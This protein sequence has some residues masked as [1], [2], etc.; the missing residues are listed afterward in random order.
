MM[1]NTDGAIKFSNKNG[2][3]VSICSSTVSGV[4]I[5]PP[6]FSIRDAKPITRQEY[7]D[8]IQAIHK[9]RG[10]ERQ[11]TTLEDLTRQV[12]A[13]QDEVKAIKTKIG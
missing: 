10:K 7:S 6:G 12:A 8:H 3:V 13:L 4:M 1:P 11:A 9:N 2:N 5:I